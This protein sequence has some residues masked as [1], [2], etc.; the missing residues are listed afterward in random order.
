LDWRGTLFEEQISRELRFAIQRCEFRDLVKVVNSV[1]LTADDN[2]SE[3]FDV[4]IKINENVIIGEAKCQKF[5]ISVLE[6]ANYLA[7]LVS[8][9]K[10][11]IRKVNWAKNH[12]EI[13]AGILGIKP[14]EIR[15]F[16][17]LVIT[18]HSIGVG[19]NLS[20]VSILDL[21]LLENYF[22]HPYPATGVVE[23]D[24]TMEI[25][26]KPFYTNSS[27]F[28]ANFYG[29]AANPHPIYRILEYLK[30]VMIYLP[31]G[32]TKP[33]GKIEFVIDTEKVPY[34]PSS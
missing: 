31:L 23:R 2:S 25:R 28:S 34:L 5:P 12:Q 3:E 26:G 22:A 17:P 6:H 9:S 32:L 7:T 21:L 8:A 16:F 33:L 14:A 18:N 19:L 11:V 1:K 29:Y 24:Q 13:I 27:E 20:D 15:E 30:P 10:Q 4:I